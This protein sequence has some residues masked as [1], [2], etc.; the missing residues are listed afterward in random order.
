MLDTLI[1]GKI[2]AI[3]IRPNIHLCY[4][5]KLI[6]ISLLNKIKIINIIISIIK[7]IKIEEENNFL[8][9]KLF[10]VYQE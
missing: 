2:K 3:E 8:L 6:A 4:L 9:F 7:E 10:L 1:K 5:S